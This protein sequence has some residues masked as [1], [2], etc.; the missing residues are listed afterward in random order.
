[1]ERENYAA[2]K[3][4]A[5]CGLPFHPVQRAWALT[6]DGEHW[7]QY[8]YLPDMKFGPYHTGPCVDDARNDLISEYEVRMEKK[9]G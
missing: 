5:L 4:C 7:R 2:D 3:N 1:M 9:N 6:W 8:Q